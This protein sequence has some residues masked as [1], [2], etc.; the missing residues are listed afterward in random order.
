MHICW[1]WGGGDPWPPKVIH[2]VTYVSKAASL[3][4]VAEEHPVCEHHEKEK[5]NIYCLSCGVP[6]CSLCK[7]FGTHKD[8][9][10]AQLD[11]V[12]S[13]QKVQRN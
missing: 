7:V 8:C 2:T 4:A 5:I 10:V 12:F 13:K 9:Q 11:V 1:I 3:P 6:T